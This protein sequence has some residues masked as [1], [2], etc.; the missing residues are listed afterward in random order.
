MKS[1]GITIPTGVA[2]NM[3]ALYG[4]YCSAYLLALVTIPYLSRVLGPAT[5]GMVAAVQ[6]FSA[7][8][9]TGVEFGFTFSATREAARARE[10]RNALGDVLSAVQGAKLLLVLVS[11][12]LALI[13]QQL[14]PLFRD[15]AEAFW[16]GVVWAVVQ[17]SNL[18]WF[19]QS[20]ERMR[21]V[22][23]LDFGI[24]VAAVA[25]TFV[26]VHGPADAWRVL[27]LQAAASFVSLLVSLG[28]AGKVASFRVPERAAM[29]RALRDGAAT[30]VPRNASALYTAGNTFLLGFF[31]R[32]EIVGFYAGA[33]RICRAVTGLLAPA[34]E[35]A[36][37]RLS[38][39]VVN[40]QARARRLARLSIL[41]MV[42][43]GLVMGGTLFLL[44]PWLVRTLLGAQY[45]AAVAPLRILC[46]LP[47]LVAL[48]NVLAIHWMLPLDLERPLNVVVVTCGVV[49]IILAVIV[50]PRFGGVGM[51]W[52]VV[53]SHLIASF[54]AWLVLRWMNL[55]PFSSDPAEEK[56]PGPP[57]VPYVAEPIAK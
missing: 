41:I 7:C 55:D 47:P 6:S 46:L 21:L 50:A 51:A 33:D 29:V 44:A 13:V 30:F 26:L 24:R 25:A 10:D 40:S 11:C 42:T 37:P 38:H 56:T 57:P 32:P 52:V 20:I 36:Y 49:N 31:A 34:S 18:M 2:N 22:S 27:A 53:V 1:D 16:W 19:F 35:A 17:G 4:V 5:W 3:F 54:G 28:M 12:G 45:G 14:L 8:L 23:I 39:M 48:R 9:L 15:H 43:V